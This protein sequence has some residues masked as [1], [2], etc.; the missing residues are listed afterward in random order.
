[1]DIIKFLRVSKKRDL[2][3]QSDSGEQQ[4]KSKGRK[5]RGEP[6]M[7]SAF[8]NSMDSPECL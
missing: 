4:Y 6:E 8:T 3:D 2:S 7:D 5:F 1:M